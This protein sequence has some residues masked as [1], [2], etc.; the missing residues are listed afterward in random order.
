MQVVIHLLHMALFRT[1]PFE[2]SKIDEELNLFE[3]IK[4]PARPRPTTLLPPRSNGKTRDCECSCKLLMMGE[5]AP[6]TC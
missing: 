4:L 5:E 1:I 6:E 2:L 3:N